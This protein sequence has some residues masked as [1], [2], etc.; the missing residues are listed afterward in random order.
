[1][2]S[3]VRVGSPGAPA[4]SPGLVR[5]DGAAEPNIIPELSPELCR[6]NT[7]AECRRDRCPPVT[8]RRGMLACPDKRIAPLA[9][10]AFATLRKRTDCRT[11]GLRRRSIRVVPRDF[12]PPL[13]FGVGVFVVLLRARAP[14]LARETL[15]AAD[16]DSR[17]TDS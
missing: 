1:M 12:L 13:T 14:A 6:L 8:M 15:R 5:L 3:T 7:G 16:A 11:R 17:Q 9:S 4:E 2:A 10:S